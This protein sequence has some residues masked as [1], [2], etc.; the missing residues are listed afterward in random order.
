MPFFALPNLSS[1]AVTECVPWTFQAPIPDAVRGPNNKKARDKWINQP[2]TNHQ[3]YSAFEGFIATERIS[4]AKAGSEGNPPL[5]MH[6][7]VAD[8]DAPVSL[9]ELSAG[10]DR[11]QG[12]KPNYLERTLSGNARLVWLFEKPISFP[13]LR[14][15]KEFLKRALAQTKFDQVVVG[16]DV[17]AW[18]NPNRYWTNSCEWLVVD[19]NA[20]I[21]FGLLNGW[22]LETAEKHLWKKDRGAVD[23][24]LPVVF[25]ELQKKHPTLPDTWPGDFVEGAQ[26]PSFWIEGSES[27]KSAIVKPTGM[28]T[29]AAHAVKPFWSWADLL[30]SSFVEKYETEMMGKAVVDIYHDGK[31]YWRKD[32]PGNWKPFPKEDI[33]SY[34]KVTRGL[35]G[36]KAGDGPSEVERAIQHIQAWAGING[37]A[38][39]VYQPPGIIVRNSNLF[40]NT[41][42]G[43]PLKM[44]SEKPA[45]GPHGNMPFLSTFFPHFLASPEALPYLQAWTSRFYRGAVD[46]QL[47]LGQIVLL[48]GGVGIGKTMWL[49]AILSK[50]VGGSADAQDY[51]MGQT[52]FNAQLFQTP[53]FF[54]DDNSITVDAN[55]HKKFSAMG[56][57]MAANTTF[58]YS[59]KFRTPCMVDWRGRVVVLANSDEE[60]VRIVPDLSISILDK[61]HLF[62]AADKPWMVF[63]REREITQILEGELPIYARYLYEYECPSHIVGSS[64]YGVRAYHEPSLMQIAEQS[65]RTAA[66]QEVIEDWRESYFKEFPD[67]ECWEGSSF[68]FLKELHRDEMARHAGLRSLSP[69]QVSSQL[70]TL[71]AKGLPITTST[72]G[73]TRIWKFLKPAPVAE[74]PLP[75]GQKFSKA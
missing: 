65:S 8:Y 2:T 39:F 75:T 11:L 64:R 25:T 9:D 74:T 68:Q 22:I 43:K 54:V 32:G 69:Q 26:G 24:P 4:D 36:Q 27:P 5:R 19:E 57:K 16:L 60:S 13:N 72:K 59:E 62:L 53:L 71:K 50:L 29:F 3:A 47:E 15:C 70:A 40:L 33:V 46:C 31:A 73:T 21:P 37:A 23:I 7:F 52:T 66:F 51:L 67:K 17:P 28:Y 10:I 20:R 44:S 48:L 61:L 14:F 12:F 30:G 63:P 42:A 45:W 41:H 56:K 38:P 34:L 6:A 35:S 18:E 49:Q 58:Q 55:T 1:R